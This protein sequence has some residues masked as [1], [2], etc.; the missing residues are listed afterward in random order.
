[1]TATI[2]RQL[3]GTVTSDKM[4]KTVVIRIERTKKHPKYL[5]QYSVRK[6]YKAHDEKNEYHTGDTVVIEEIRP[7][8]KDKRWRV[9][10]KVS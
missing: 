6:S 2:K 9:V 5:K 4:D 8:S 10:K 7:M 1:M 3:Q